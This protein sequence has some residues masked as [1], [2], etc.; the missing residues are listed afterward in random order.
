MR[1]L[2]RCSC[3]GLSWT[4]RTTRWTSCSGKTRDPPSFLAQLVL[5][6]GWIKISCYLAKLSSVIYWSVLFWSIRAFREAMELEVMPACRETKALFFAFQRWLQMLFVRSRISML[7]IKPE[8]VAFFLVTVAFFWL[9]S[10]RRW[11][12]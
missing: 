6:S 7:L 1:K 12:K 4:L 8:T 5:L 3:A 2:G 9:Q 11:N 10:G